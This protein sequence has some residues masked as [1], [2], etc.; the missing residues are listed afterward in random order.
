MEGHGGPARHRPRREAKGGR[1][2]VSGGGS[3]AGPGRG[4][5][6]AGGTAGGSGGDSARSATLLG[7]WRYRRRSPARPT[8]VLPVLGP[9]CGVTPC[10][11]PSRSPSAGSGCCQAPGLA[12]DARAAVCSSRRR[13]RRLDSDSRIGRVSCE[14][15]AYALPTR[16]SGR[17]GSAWRALQR[18]WLRPR[19]R[20]SRRRSARPDRPGPAWPGSVQATPPAGGCPRGDPPAE[21]APA[22]RLPQCRYLVGPDRPGPYRTGP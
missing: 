15:A 22:L 2:G 1:P 9:A 5:R 17:A 11:S 13:S 18:A 10:G 6:F 21:P 20:R 7:L 4:G 14:V 12:A 3:V 16:I 19:L 8:R